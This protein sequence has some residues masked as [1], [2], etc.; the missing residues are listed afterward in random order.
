MYI[1]GLDSHHSCQQK[2]TK[3][4]YIYEFL[5]MWPII[6]KRTGHACL[7]QAQY[8]DNVSDFLFK[9]DLILSF[10]R[11]RPQTGA[12]FFF[13]LVLLSLFLQLP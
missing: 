12:H 11:H 1:P 10:V 6:G 9:Y 3:L 7:N 5:N 8:F 2:F 13:F 4:K